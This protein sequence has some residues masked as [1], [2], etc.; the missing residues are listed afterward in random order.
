MQ[1][2]GAA[3]FFLERT[4]IRVY[5]FIRILFGKGGIF[6]T[7]TGGIMVPHPPLIIPQV[8]RG[9]EKEIQATIDA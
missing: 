6:M 4:C 8:G 7:V 1:D 3:Y 9:R 5:N 2:R